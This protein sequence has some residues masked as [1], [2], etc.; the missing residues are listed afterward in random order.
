M[1]T[2]T[3]EIQTA[4][5]TDDH[6]LHTWIHITRPDGTKEAWGLYPKED[7]IG[8]IIYGEGEVR[9]EST[10]KKYTSSTG[11]IEMNRDQFMGFR[12][13][14]AVAMEQGINYSIPY[15]QQCT[16]WALGALMAADVL[17]NVP[18]IIL[19]TFAVNPITLT[20]I[21][22]LASLYAEIGQAEMAHGESILDGRLSLAEDM[23]Q[24][25]NSLSEICQAIGQAELAN[26]E[27]L[28]DGSLALSEHIDQLLA[29]A[30]DLILAAGQLE[31]EN[32]EALL[33][34]SL[35]LAD[36]I[37]EGMGSLL[38]AVADMIRRV[39]F[40]EH[41][42][43]GMFGFDDLDQLNPTI[44][45]NF[46]AAQSWVR[47]V[48]PLILDL[49]GDGIE[50]VGLN[51]GNPLLF[52]HDGDGVKTSSGWVKTDDGFLVLDRNGNGAID[53]GTELFGDSTPLAGGGKAVDGFAALAREDTNNDGKVD[54]A[55]ARFTNLRVWRDLNSDGV[56]Q[57][58]ELFTL[59]ALGISAI[60]VTKTDAATRLA[61][62]NIITGLGTYTRSDGSTSTMG[63]SVMGDV[64][65]AENTFV[66]QFTESVPIS[67]EAA[68]LPQLNGAGQVRSLREAASLS[69]NLLTT[70]G[71]YAAGATGDE[72]R[73]LLDGLLK[74][75]SDAIRRWTTPF[76]QALLAFCPLILDLD[77]N[78]VQVTSLADGV[79][80][81]HDGN[82]FL[83]S[84]AWVGGNDGLLVWDRNN[85]GA[86]TTGNELF[87]D[88]TLMKNGR[89]GQNGFDVLAEY[90]DNQDHKIDANDA[91]WTN[92]QL[93]VDADRDGV[94]AASELHNLSEYNIQSI[95]TA[96]TTSGNIQKGSET[97]T[98]G[99]QAN[100]IDDR[101]F[102]ANA[103]DSIARDWL[104][105]PQEIAE[106][107]DLR[108]YGNVYN[109][110][111]AM[112][113]DTSGELAALVQQF[114][115]AS[116]GA[117]R[118]ALMTQ[119]LFKWTGSDQIDPHSR[120]NTAWGTS[121]DARK[122]TVLEKFNGTRFSQLYSERGPEEN[123][124]P[125]AIPSLNQAYSALFGMMYSQLMAQTHLKWLYDKVTLTW[126]ETTQNI[127][128]NQ[129]A[130]LAAL[131]ALLATDR[132]RGIETVREYT[133]SLVESPYSSVMGIEHFL[134]AL[135]PQGSD[136]MGPLDAIIRNVFPGSTLFGDNGDNTLELTLG[137]DTIL[138]RG[139]NDTLSGGYG[140]EALY[141][142]EGNDTLIGGLGNDTRR[143][144]ILEV[145]T[146]RRIF[147]NMTSDEWRAAA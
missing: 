120:D 48:D 25:L 61:N 12:E 143:H 55:D 134:E 65:L 67:P 56:S 94:S 90:D 138:G 125:Q 8:N 95:G 92:L 106:L 62:G 26:G 71:N 124:L 83:E 28:L 82:G 97:T 114:A 101:T 30:R 104:P 99:S 51:A 22:L 6:S 108:G 119:I 58:S 36:R 85:D 144:R 128:A 126:D 98:D 80:F 66:S 50:T 116:T 14:L 121:F 43:N 38:D 63:T 118:E 59:A 96:Y 147:S 77:R 46:N 49:D 10:E 70:L 107:P 17:P 3:I 117:A 113:R 88:R 42:M 54:A 40:T 18:T 75:W 131:D 4:I 137:N 15:N 19:P 11:P 13:Y 81:D 112:V 7:G 105:V 9:F 5:A 32:G 130:V 44:A 145:L 23:G 68:A 102:T 123:P 132:P 142:E 72:Q 136:V 60:N 141:G 21:N 37:A 20:G 64:D 74:A 29:A 24:F 135:S 33:D 109:L 76:D 31:Q 2:F 39:G 52:D 47:R 35:A 91:I 53:N 45:D 140:A 127:V 73:A 34:G 27:A 115:Q 122:L 87:G 129:D 133:R 86:I 93:W 139:G 16:Q 79:H 1:S 111:Q 41:F 110:H 69:S 146:N 89:W 103:V 100:A 84:T 57:G 78:G